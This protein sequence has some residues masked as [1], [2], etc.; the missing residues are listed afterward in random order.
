MDRTT[1][2]VVATRKVGV[3]DKQIMMHSVTPA[4]INS[5]VFIIFLVVCSFHF[6]LVKVTVV[7]S[8]NSERNERT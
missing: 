7:F 1:P 2:T 4:R 8:N 6:N 3:V 5:N